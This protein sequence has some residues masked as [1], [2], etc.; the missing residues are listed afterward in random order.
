MIP[1][2]PSTA[3]AQVQPR[4]EAA[5]ALVPVVYQPLRSNVW[6][7]ETLKSPP[8]KI[9]F[10][11]MSVFRGPRSPWSFCIFQLFTSPDRSDLNFPTALEIHN[12]G[13]F[14][15]SVV[16]VF[17]PLLHRV[18]DR[19]GEVAGVVRSRLANHDCFRQWPGRRRS[20]RVC[21]D[22]IKGPHLEGQPVGDHSGTPTTQVAASR[23]TRTH[24]FLSKSVRIALLVEEGSGKIKYFIIIS[25]DD[26]AFS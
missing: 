22:F 25:Y 5:L 9:G 19:P 26:D 4:T 11:A 2:P 17:Q 6:W 21:S 1:Q 10:S 20:R 18:Y 14:E 15:I 8:P 7:E 13:N 23:E 16:S 3:P 12:P 24:Y